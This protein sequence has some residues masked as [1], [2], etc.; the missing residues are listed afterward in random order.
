MAKKDGNPIKV[1]LVDD[2]QM[3]RQGIKLILTD[4][5]KVNIDVVAEASNGLDAC[6]LV[7]EVNPDVVVMDVHMKKM[8]GVRATR[9][10]ME[11]EDPPAIVMLTMSKQDDYV[12]EA[13]KAGARGYYLKD[14]DSSELINA[15]KLAADGEMILSPELAQ[16][17]LREF[18]HIT[19]TGDVKSG[20]A[21]LADREI[22]ILRQVAAGHTNLAIANNLGLSEKTIKNQLSGVFNKLKLSNRTQA[23]IFALRHGLV[24][25]EEL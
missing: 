22:D 14:S 11:K 4:H 5:P 18:R 1:L 25:L 20:L 7:D 3:F 16:R 19:T 10:I 8:D 6:D 21:S 15:I 9:K 12:F 23:A 17:V 24:T 2:H 13:I